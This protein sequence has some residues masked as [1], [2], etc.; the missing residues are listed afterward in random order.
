MSDK[1]FNEGDAVEVLFSADR[2]WTPA[3]YWRRSIY[4]DFDGV[5]EHI[6]KPIDEPNM[7]Y[8]GQFRDDCIRKALGGGE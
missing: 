4:P 5:Y 2:E 8:F 6:V 1:E 7:R 3:I